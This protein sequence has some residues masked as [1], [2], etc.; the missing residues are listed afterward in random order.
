[1]DRERPRILGAVVAA[2]IRGKHFVVPR[3]NTR[4]EPGDHVVLVGRPK[5]AKAAQDLFLKKSN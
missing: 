1:M 2:V 3:G 4:I 5:A